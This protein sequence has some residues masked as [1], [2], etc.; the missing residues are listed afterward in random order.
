MVTARLGDAGHFWWMCSYYGLGTLFWTK[1]Y[2]YSLIGKCA[3][4]LPQY[5]CGHQRTASEGEGFLLCGSGAAAW[6]GRPAQPALTCWAVLL[7]YAGHCSVGQ[8]RRGRLPSF[9]LYFPS[10]LWSVCA[11]LLSPVSLFLLGW[12]SAHLGHYFCSSLYKIV[13]S[14]WYFWTTVFPSPGFFKTD[15]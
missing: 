10:A 6:A 13:Y 15:L 9:F 8:Q 11:R 1:D 3:V 5:M 7:W 14:L 2:F 4:V 12:L